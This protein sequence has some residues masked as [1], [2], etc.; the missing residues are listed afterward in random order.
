MRQ[1]LAHRTALV[2]AEIVVCTAFVAGLVQADEHTVTTIAVLGFVDR[3]P[4]VELAPL[5]EA[6]AEMLVTDLSQYAG[7]QSVERNRVTELLGEKYLNESGLVDKAIALKA[8]R[9]LAADYLV[10]GTFAGSDGKIMVEARLF[11]TGQSEPTQ[12]WKMSADAKELVA[13]EAELVEKVLTAL[14]VKGI[15]RSRLDSKSTAEVRAAVMQFKNNSMAGGLDSMQQGFADILQATL[16]GL[17]HVNLVERERLNLVLNEQK[18]SLSLVNPTQ[19]IAVGKLFGASR[20]IY[21]SFFEID[22][23]LRIEVRVVD[24][25]TAIVVRYESAVGSVESF[26]DLIVQ[27]ALRLADDLAIGVPT[28]AENRLRDALPA[29]SLEAAVHYAAG[30]A[31]LREAKFEDALL[32]SRRLLLLEPDNV[33]AQILQIRCLE[34]R[35]RSAEVI[36]AAKRALA[37]PIGATDTWTRTWMVHALAHHEFNKG[38]TQEALGI[39]RNYLDKTTIS[40]DRYFLRRSLAQ[41]L[42]ALHQFDEAV[43]T[44]EDAVGDPSVKHTEWY[45]DAL[46]ELLRMHSRYLQG[47]IAKDADSEE[48]LRE[49]STKANQLLELILTE[50][51]GRRDREWRSFA[52]YL[53]PDAIN[54][55]WRSGNKLLGMSIGQK[56]RILRRFINV[57]SWVNSAVWT[58]HLEL[59]KI[60]QIREKWSD[61]IISHRYVADHPQ[62]APKGTV[63]NFSDIRPGEFNSSYSNLVEALFQIA[64]IQQQELKEPDDALVSYQQIVNEYGLCHHRGIDVLQFLLAADA[65]PRPIERSVLVVGGGF[66]GWMSWNAILKPLG[67]TVHGALETHWSAATFAPYDLVILVRQGS[68]VLEPTDVFAFRSYVANGGSLFVVVSPGFQ[69]ASPSV[70]NPLLSFFGVRADSKM[71]IR[72]ESISITPHPITEGVTKVMAKNAVALEAPAD[73]SLV[74]AGEGTLLAVMPYRRGRVAVASF[75]QWYLPGTVVLGDW[76]MR[77]PGIETGT[78]T[79]DPRDLPVG[80]YNELYLPLLKKVVLWLNEQVGYRAGQRERF[81]KAQAASLAVQFGVRPVDSLTTAMDEFLASSGSETDR[82]EALWAAA[83][84]TYQP[85]FTR[86]YCK[87]TDG[88]RIETRSQPVPAKYDLLVTDF[89]DSELYP[90]ALWRRS[91]AEFLRIRHV[92]ATSFDEWNELAKTFDKVDAPRGS[93]PWLWT[94]LRLGEIRYQQGDFDAALTNFQNVSE[95]IAQGPERLMGIAGM[96]QCHLAAKRI[97]DAKRLYRL[98][99]ESDDVCWPLFDAH[100][101]HAWQPIDRKGHWTT[102]SRRL[103]FA[104][105]RSMDE[106][107]AE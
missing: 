11:K 88:D 67:Y 53:L 69:P 48:K 66:D 56:E 35:R 83:E 99:T 45:P 86:K 15:K 24:C 52:T 16:S 55:N 21:G 60:C 37:G 61:A 3:G 54:L 26:D 103:G 76:W 95:A 84:A 44:M 13:I 23:Q 104:R 78:F 64:A 12:S 98:L 2:F 62:F 51:D 38:N 32:H 102:T 30:Q 14:D 46:R 87:G 49:H 107:A 92:A 59:A 100:D 42:H 105:L 29:R 58:A 68:I 6:L 33:D 71:A 82:E 10:S 40:Q 4:S 106:K 9:E 81:Q 80:L 22:K 89:T 8:G 63:P 91:D 90:F 34:G 27:L 43:T 57:F 41:K 77:K 74:R 1:P 20:L 72:A 39:L 50:A 18:L 96:A 25:E 94:Q 28:D 17:P 101:G 75:G 73:A 93:R 65:P 85:V 79:N 70:L 97:D 19:A 31:S 5:R 36:E 7:L 47:A